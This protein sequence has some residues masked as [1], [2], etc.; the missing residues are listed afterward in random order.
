MRDA[1]PLALLVAAAIG[2]A[3][4]ARAEWRDPIGGATTVLP[5]HFEPDDGTLTVHISPRRVPV[6][7][8]GGT[9]P[10]RWSQPLTDRH[11][12]AG[13]R[14][15]PLDT[16]LQEAIGR[17]EPIYDPTLLDGPND[18][19]PMHVSAG[20]AEA[21]DLFGDHWRLASADANV[22]MDARPLAAAWTAAAAHAVGG[23]RARIAA[24]S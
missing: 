23:A 18:I 22:D 2:P 7:P 14:Y 9:A 4:A 3:G 15:A 16:R 11:L 5:A 1:L 6:Q 17:I 19:V 8:D 12:G 21:R 24:P 20:T 13:E 10:F